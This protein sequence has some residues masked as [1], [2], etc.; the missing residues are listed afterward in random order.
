V[1]WFVKYNKLTEYENYFR[2]K[3]LLY[4]P[5]NENEN[6][7]KHNFPTWEATYISS[8]TIMKTN[9]SILHTMLIQHG[10]N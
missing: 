2:E 6:T 1:I 9:E 5:F 7:L 3:K 4:I 8:E 10:V